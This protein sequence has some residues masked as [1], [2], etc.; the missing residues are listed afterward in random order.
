MNVRPEQEEFDE[1]ALLTG[2]D[3][4]FIEKDWF[5]TQVVAAIASFAYEGFLFVFGGGT[6]LVFVAPLIYGIDW[7][8]RT[9]HAL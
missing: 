9:G 6:A 3:P 5:V 8:H 2:I 7:E 1:L 4:S